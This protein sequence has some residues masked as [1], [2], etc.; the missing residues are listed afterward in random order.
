MPGRKLVMASAAGGTGYHRSHLFNEHRVVEEP[1][2]A[3]AAAL[4][5][6]PAFNE[7]AISDT[8]N[9][10]R[11]GRYRLACR[12]NVELTLMCAAQCPSHY[13]LVTFGNDIVNRNA[14][15]WKSR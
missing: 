4:V 8:E 2:Q 15:V 1:H 10:N 12:G 9:V 3:V 13:D 5:F 6:E 7:L 11:Y 14:S